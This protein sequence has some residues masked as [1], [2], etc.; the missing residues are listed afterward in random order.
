MMRE[1]TRILARIIC[2]LFFSGDVSA[3]ATVSEKP[4]EV[5]RSMVCHGT[6]IEVRSICGKS[7]EAGANY[8]CTEQR[9]SVR[10]KQGPSI[11]RDLL[12]KESMDNYHIATS[13][14]CVAADAKPYIFILLDN[15]GNCD[16]CEVAGLIDM[17]GKWV[18]YGDRWFVPAS[19]RKQVSKAEGRWLLTHPVP[20]T[21]KAAE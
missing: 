8:S 10:N 14:R 3:Q 6:N 13:M 5:R 18:Y 15:G 17:N 11:S 7:S 2:A 19:E 21:D 16:D 4:F 20:L 12:E 9:I 1:Q